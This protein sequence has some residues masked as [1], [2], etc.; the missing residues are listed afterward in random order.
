MFSHLDFKTIGLALIFLAASGL[1][2]ANAHPA[3]EAPGHLHF[4]C[5]HAKNCHSHGH[6]AGHH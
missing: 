5:H 4:H 2:G 6:N 1:A 3:E